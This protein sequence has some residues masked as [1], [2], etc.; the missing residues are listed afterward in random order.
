[1]SSSLQ[2]GLFHPWP[3]FHM[4]LPH[5]RPSPQGPSP[6]SGGRSWLPFIL[7]PS[8]AS[9]SPPGAAEASCSGPRPPRNTQSTPATREG[10][11]GTMPQ[12]AAS[13]VGRM[14]KEDLSQTQGGWCDGEAAGAQAETQAV[15]RG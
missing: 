9:L 2:G 13:Q 15:V 12:E 14:T 6:P 1:M 5:G 7:S 8:K 4:R 10:T 3:I 11:T